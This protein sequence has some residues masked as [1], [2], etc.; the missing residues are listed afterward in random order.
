MRG[1]NAALDLSGKT[2]LRQL[3]SVL[4]ACDLV[5]SGDSGPMHLGVAVGTPV[6]ALFGATN[7]ARHGPYGSQ[8]TVVQAVAPIAHGSHRPTAEEGAA[9][10]EAV[11]VDA[12]LPVIDAALKS[13]CHGS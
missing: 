6:V 13:K 5:I 7:P 12:L 1:A 2:S 10:M 4:A 3:T 8:H 9:A 11:T